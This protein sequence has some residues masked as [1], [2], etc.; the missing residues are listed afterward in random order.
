[1]TP[2]SKFQGSLEK[3][4]SVLE[5]V[6]SELDPTVV[7]NRGNSLFPWLGNVFLNHI[8][9]LVEGRSLIRLS[10]V[11]CNVQSDGEEARELMNSK[12]LRGVVPVLK[13]FGIGDSL[14]PSGWRQ[15][16]NRLCN[17][18]AKERSAQA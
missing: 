7:S 17:H 1:M 11:A 8:R 2:L 10:F 5:Q 4:G 3:Y 13:A 6:G 12:H 18:T 15:P 16:I 14:L 9:S